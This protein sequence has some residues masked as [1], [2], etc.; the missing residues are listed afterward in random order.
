MKKITYL[1]LIL[2][3]FQT[4]HSQLA[5]EGFENNTTNLPVGWSSIN[6]SG[7]IQ[8]WTVMVNNPSI[9]SYEGNYA[10]YISTEQM[11]D[12][13]FTEDWLITPQ[14]TLP[15]LPQLRFYSRLL[16]ALDQ[17]NTF[18]V[19]ITNGDPTD[20]EGYEEVEIW[21]ELE[22]NPTQTDYAEKLV[23]L[24]EEFTGQQVYVAFV[25][26]GDNGDRWLIDNAKVFKQC[27]APENED[28]GIITDTTAEL[29]WDNPAGV[30]TWEIEL[31]P[32]TSP[33]TGSGTIYNDELPYVAEGLTPDTEYKYFVR[34]VCGDE[35]S[36]WAGPV[37]FTT[38]SEGD[39]C[40]APIVINTLPF[41]TTDHTSNYADTYEGLPGGDSCGNNGAY[42][43]Q[44]ND[45]V[46]QYIAEFT[47]IIT[48]DLTAS[49]NT[50]VF[51]YD[52][53][54]DIGTDCVGGSVTPW[55]GT[56]TSIPEFNV[57]AGQAYY[58]LIS[59]QPDTTP[60]TLIIQQVSCEP[61]VGLP[62]GDTTFTSAE[63][64]WTNPTDA[65]SWEIVIQAPG[66]GIPP[67]SGET[68]TTNT[69]YLADGLTPGTPYEYYVRADCNDGSFSAWSGPYLFNTTTCT[70]A[71]QC[72]YT[73][74]M[75][76]Y[77]GSGWLDNTMTVSQNG[78]TIA[79]LNPFFD[80]GTVEV[81]TTIALC[82]DIPV[83]IFWNEGGFDPHLIGLTVKNSFGQTAYSKPAGEGS[84]NSL[85]YE[86]E[87]ICDAAA[88]LIPND[89]TAS[90]VTF[91][92]ADLSW[93]GLPAGQW[94][95][96]ITEAGDPAPD[97]ST[98]GTATITNPV[99]AG[100]LTAATNYEYYVRMVCNG[101]TFSDWSEP[102]P[103]S[104][105]IC[106]P[107]NQCDYT[108]IMSSEFGP[109]YAGHTVTISQNGINVAVIG[110]EFINGTEMPV[111]IALCNDTPFEV[112]WNNTGFGGAI[113]LSIVNPFEQT[114]YSMTGSE[115]PGTLLYTGEVD[116]DAPACI[117]PADL[118]AENP[119]MTTIDL[120]WEGLPTGSWEYYIVEAGE[121]APTPATTGE[122]AATN[123]VTA[124]GLTAATNYEYYVRMICSGGT[125]S[126]WAGPFA[127][128]TAVCEPGDQCLFT[129]EMTSEVGWGWEDNTMTITQAGII[130]AIIG[131][132]FTLGNSG[133][134]QVPLCPDETV[135]IFWNTDGW[136][137]PDDKGLIVYSPY[138]EEIFS[139]PAGIGTQGTTIFAGTFSC[140]APPCP[141]PQQLNVPDITSASAL[142]EWTEMGTATN[143]EVVVLPI[144]FSGT[145]RSRYS[146]NCR[147][148]FI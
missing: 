68:V 64:S 3:F 94:E 43:L 62:V 88:C 60:F 45:V 72:E 33:T 90:N 73:F 92:T 104:T 35:A 82:P 47:G 37:F 115:V 40:A 125:A 66:T 46:Y 110:P 61:P 99:T 41:S 119:T 19:M 101:G 75:S 11:P 118:T 71:E 78:I 53:C 145:N 48:F 134:V 67:G 141:K 131:S 16:L 76:N 130:I 49:N 113:G 122:A 30:D 79:V 89:L 14:F 17:G 20:L 117:P 91:T 129:F 44:G 84:Q 80:F 36:S 8:S 6:V 108:F 70:P 128:N 135:E 83:K 126:E 42:F 132:S 22:I 39:T 57:T 69:D 97:N 87:V 29:V 18:K 120:E 96:Y 77:T 86:G 100:G 1:I 21:T 139:K 81:T 52:D 38:V 7:P 59:S 102:H 15:S 74:I 111:T 56:T 137:N 140:A 63:L 10:A 124:G 106:A 4:G 114:V 32:V 58:I 25:T 65:D 55:T 26:M 121:P 136:G 133:T 51:I 107:G 105:A 95:Y 146:C 109:G 9:P 23:D 144:G 127:F 148:L 2:L 54:N 85:L 50:G 24:P 103:F 123:P 5:E 93:D 12:G 143:W 98:P 34:S 31:L 116:C 138:M 147:F 13:E 142:L 112:F 27:P 28:T